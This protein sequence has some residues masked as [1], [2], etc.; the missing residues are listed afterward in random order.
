MAVFVIRATLASV[1]G[2]AAMMR[3]RM[4]TWRVCLDLAVHRP[5]RDGIGEDQ[6]GCQ[7]N[8]TRDAPM[9]FTRTLQR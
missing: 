5:E 4:R 7:A 3:G 8:R 9:Q 6:E 2:F 1:R